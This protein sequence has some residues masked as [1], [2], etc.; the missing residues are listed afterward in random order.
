VSDLRP[1]LEAFNGAFW[2]PA[3]VT[4]PGGAP[5]ATVAMEIQPFMERFPTDAGT[6][7]LAKSRRRVGLRLDQL[8][9]LSRPGLSWPPP[10]TSIV[11]GGQTRHVEGVDYQ[12]DEIVHVVVR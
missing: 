9:P 2:E 11:M 1:P 7:S 5:V 4:L 6:W 12:D 8:P 3:T 10:G